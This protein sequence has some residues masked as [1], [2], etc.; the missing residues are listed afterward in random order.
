MNVDVLI[1]GAATTGSYFARKLAEQGVKVLVIDRSYEEKI[2]SKYDIFHICERDFEKHGLPLPTE[3]EDRV[4]RFSHSMNY[5][6]FG[7]HPKPGECPVIGMHMHLYTLRM[8]RWAKEAGAQIEYGATFQKLLYGKGGEVVGAVYEKN[9]QLHEVHAKLVADCSGIPSVARRS[10]PD[11]CVVENFEISPRDMFYVILRYVTYSNPKDW[12]SG[13]RGWTFYKTWEAPQADPHGAILG[14]GANLSFDFAEKIYDVFEK[15][16]ALPEHTI[17]YIERGATPYRRPPY[18]F[19][20]DGFVV[21]GDA[22]CLTKPS[23]GEGV[24]SSMVHADVV[25]DVVLKLFREE[26]PLSLENLW[27]I[28]KRYIQVQ[29][30][31]FA[32]QLAMLVGAVATNAQENDFFFRND[33]IFSRKSFEAMGEGRE[34]TFSYLDLIMMV[35]KML[36]GV[37]TGKLRMSTIH[38]LVNAMS[39][40][41]KV[42]KLYDC[43]PDTPAGFGAWRKEADTVWVTCGSM[44]EAAERMLSEL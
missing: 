19:V 8:N 27:P 41:N 34:L 14:I 17:D 12:I 10:L 23:A 6:A 5:S 18:S 1:I 43:Y 31:A 3:G 29:G 37:L 36:W 2:G 32:S 20:S 26:K 13:S 7:R 25:L 30:K 11:D 24:T 9:G 21:M 4:F 33:I 16:I 38:S 40:S 39:D 35:G 44:T 22:A 28:N 15:T 42:S